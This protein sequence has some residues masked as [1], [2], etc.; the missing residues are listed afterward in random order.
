MANKPQMTISREEEKVSGR[1]AS[2]FV[3]FR[4]YATRCDKSLLGCDLSR[5]AAS[6][7]DAKGPTDKDTKQIEGEVFK[8]A[9]RER[10]YGG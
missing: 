3:G 8:M 9:G 5:G 1:K 4:A 6:L 10:R 7:E 2:L